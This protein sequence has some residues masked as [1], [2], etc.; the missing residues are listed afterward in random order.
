MTTLSG[1][2]RPG[3]DAAE[4][5]TD[6]RPRLVRRW[7]TAMVLLPALIVAVLGWRHRWM[8][9]DGLIFTRPVR[10][11]LAGHGPVF[12]LGERAEASTSTLWHWLLV[13]GSW[14]TGVEAAPFAVYFGL[15]C[16]V[17]GYAAA[18]DATRRLHLPRL[19]APFLVPCGVLILIALPPVWDFAT[20]GLETGLTTL[21][22]AGCWWLLV[23]LPHD[24][25]ARTTYGLAFLTGLGPLVRPDLAIATLGF[26]TALAVIRRPRPL[27]ALALFATAI[28]T[29]LLYELFRM[30]YYGVLLP[31]PALTKE[32]TTSEWT[33]GREYVLDLV[34]PYHL[35]L[36]AL[37]LAVFAVLTLA[38]RPSGVHRTRIV[39]CVTPMLS[40]LAMLLYIARV[41]G[42]FM[43]GRM[44]LPGLFLLLLPILTVPASRLA[45]PV[46]TT[47]IG[48]A[49]LC[50]IG[51]RVGY[52][53]IGPHGIA[54]ERGFYTHTLR[55]ANPVT[56]D[57]YIERFPGFPTMTRGPHPAYR[58]TLLHLTP[59]HAFVIGLRPELDTPIVTVWPSLGMNGAATPL[60][61][62]AIDDL[63]LAYPLG[64]H[65][66]LTTRGRPGHEKQIDAAWVLA[67]YAD[68]AAPL[69]ADIDPIR[70]AA[71]RHA[72][73][74]GPLKEL[75]DSVR[76]PMTWTRFAKNLTGA[77]TRTTFRFPNDP[78]TATQKFC[79][80]PPNS[81]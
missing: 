45:I 48:W 31:L 32:A 40:G 30:G 56:A 12:N 28:A 18:L 1:L 3:S 39:V 24:E 21:W 6:P 78:L 13:A 74:C 50:A 58:H 67:E 68:P 72:L 71:A 42:D 66:E 57:T 14:T 33:R 64:A 76:A 52:D 41:G 81:P 63:A 59:A 35:W 38:T 36:P 65:I 27:R 26:L 4:P 79:P 10:Q 5:P 8:S 54:N 53:G 55:T 2:G 73:T 61:G 47:L 20:S 15:A 70:V 29:P 75:Q 16:S 69:P 25:R 11:V 34:T 77:L 44:L 46:A 49:M 17:A 80:T 37:V 51:F 19:E 62:I 23:R 9:D 60:R 43:H 22:T 7:N